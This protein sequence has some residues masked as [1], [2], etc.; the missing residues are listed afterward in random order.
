MVMYT[1][2]IKEFMTKRQTILRK[3]LENLLD[4]K[5]LFLKFILFLCKGPNR[6]IK[7]LRK[8]LFRVLP[9]IQSAQK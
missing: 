3:S 1:Q 6:K 9:K 8:L 4:I 5:S 2:N 7:I